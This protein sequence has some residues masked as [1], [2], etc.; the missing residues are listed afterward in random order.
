MNFDSLHQAAWQC[1]LTPAVDD[2]LALTDLIAEQW[3]GGLLDFH[4]EVAPFTASE[5]VESLPV[6]GRP[7]KPDLVPPNQVPQRGFGKPSQRAALL[8]ALAHIEFNAV[9]LAWDAVYRFRGM[10]KRFY[11]DWVTVATDEARHFRLLQQRLHALDHEY[12][13][14]VAHNGLWD[15]A[16][17]TD[18]DL[19]ARM[20]LV[21]R[22]LEARSLDVTPMIAERLRSAGDPE[23]AEVIKLIETEELA[24][25]Q[26]G[27]RWFHYACDQQGLEPDTYFIDL[28]KQH[29]NAVKG[30]FN[31]TARIEAGFSEQELRNL[32][33][34]A[35]A[36]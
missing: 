21:P 11:E 12:G 10:P 5:N 35:E 30:P 23:S 29:M 15:M 25:V 13:D 27:T 22:V 17:K 19:A 9:N 24:H 7:L 4:S 33:A 14:F 20:A 6:P 18:H 3:R 1:L 26:A 28:V 34:L 2:K 8:H 36:C 31:T 32:G 16:V